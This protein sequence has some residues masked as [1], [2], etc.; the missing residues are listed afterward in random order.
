MDVL[1]SLNNRRN[2]GEWFVIAGTI[3]I[4]AEHLASPSELIALTW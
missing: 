4:I 1:W 2:A 3:F